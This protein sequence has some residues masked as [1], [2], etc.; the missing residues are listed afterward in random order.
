VIRAARF[1]LPLMLAV[2]GG[3]PERFRQ[4]VDL[5]LRA[6]AEYE[7]PGL[8]VGLHTLGYVAATD[9][10]AIETQWPHWAETFDRAARE[11]GWRRP[12]RAQFDAE[13]EHGSLFVGSPE[14]VAQRLASTIRALDVDR[15][16]LHYAIGKLPFE[17]RLESIELLG[18]E[19]FPRV[20]E[21]LATDPPE[22]DA[23]SARRDGPGDVKSPVRST[24]GSEE[25]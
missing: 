14:T 13:V 1:G 15:L 18:R 7:K 20:R 5:Y 16:D 6:L 22:H 4:L 2:I 9:E 24:H 19:V 8:A 25:A 3:R 12:T 11:R 17:K 23:A 21:L 10:E